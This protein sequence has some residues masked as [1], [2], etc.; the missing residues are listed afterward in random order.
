MVTFLDVTNVTRMWKSKKHFQV[1]CNCSIYYLLTSGIWKV[2]RITY[3]LWKK[4]AF[5]SRFA[6]KSLLINVR[7]CPLKVLHIKP[8]SSPTPFNLLLKINTFLFNLQ[9][10]L[11]I[12]RTPFFKH[13][14]NSN[15]F[16]RWES[17][18]DT[19]HIFGLEWTDI[20]HYL[21]QIYRVLL[22]Y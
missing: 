4:N 11:A 13:Q 9:R 22:Y 2:N 19:L 16:I 8:D 6:K 17:N 7:T 15:V 10:F 18:S 3:T 5:F 21:N 20:K 14:M 12:D 1:I